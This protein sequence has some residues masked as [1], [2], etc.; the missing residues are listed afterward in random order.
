M[1]AVV[2]KTSS[3]QVATSAAY[4]NAAPTRRITQAAAESVKG[5][6]VSVHDTKAHGSVETQLRSFLV[7]VLVGLEWPASCTGGFTR[8]GKSVRYPLNTHLEGAT[9]G[10]DTLGRE[11][12]LPCRKS[13]QDCLVVQT[14][15]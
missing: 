8:W 10:V 9:A 1:Y 14:V 13:K 5:K 15:A 7:L 3:T 4:R 6:V 12:P 11:N 2:W